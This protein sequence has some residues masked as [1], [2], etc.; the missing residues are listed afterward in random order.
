M[1]DQSNTAMELRHNDEPLGRIDYGGAVDIHEEVP[2]VQARFWM[3][4]YRLPLGVAL[5]RSCLPRPRA[6]FVPFIVR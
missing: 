2:Y 6:H 1:E 3:G 4:F 5:R